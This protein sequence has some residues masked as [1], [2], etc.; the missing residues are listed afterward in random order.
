MVFRLKP[1]SASVIKGGLEFANL[2]SPSSPNRK[3]AF[4]RLG[5]DVGL[6]PDLRNGETDFGGED[7]RPE[8]GDISVLA[9]KKMMNLR[10]KIEWVLALLVELEGQNLAQYRNQA[11]SSLES[12]PQLLAV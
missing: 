2:E 6:F 8:T 12:D 4:S 10:S 7:L 11:S 1:S 9:S 3:A 5:P